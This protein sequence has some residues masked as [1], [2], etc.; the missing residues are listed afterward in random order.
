MHSITQKC[1]EE[2]NILYMSV[3][4]GIENKHCLLFKMAKFCNLIFG[5]LSFFQIAKNFFWGLQQI[6]QPFKLRRKEG[7]CVLF[8]MVSHQ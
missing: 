6:Q 5:I 7:Q 8:E 1:N 3:L 4:S 2:Q